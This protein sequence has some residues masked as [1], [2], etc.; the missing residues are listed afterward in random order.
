MTKKNNH[1]EV[2]VRI[3]PSPTGLLHFGV[4]R[5]AL[6]N[7]LFAKKNGG[8]FIV[9]IEDTDKER[10]KKKYETSIVEGFKWL[11]LQ[12]DE[13]PIRQ[14]ERTELYKKYLQKLL[15]SK[16]AFWCYHTKEEL[17]KEKAEQMKNGEAPRHVC[18]YYDLSEKAGKKFDAK[19]GIIRFRSSDQKIVFK[20]LIRGNLEFDGK[21]LGDFSIAKNEDTP[22]YNLAVVVDDDEMR[23]SHVMRGEDH[24]SN[25][26]KQIVIYEA[27]GFEQPQFAHFPMVLNTDR[28]KMSKR[29]N[30]VSLIAY[31]EEGYLPEAMV[32]FM[33]LLGWNPGTEQEIFSL[34]ELTKVFSLERVHKGG[35]VFDIKRLEWINGH[36]IRQMKPDKL[37]QEC[38]PYLEEAGLIKK[39]NSKIQIVATKK[40]VNLDYVQR[41]VVLEQERL[42]KL[43]EIGELTKFFFVDKLDYSAELLIWKKM[44]LKDVKKN[45]EILKDILFKT[46]EFDQKSLERTIMPLTKKHGTGE[47]L[48]PLRVSLTGQKASPGPFEIMGVLG[49]KETLA[50]VGKAIELLEN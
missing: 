13:G 23:I 31:K 24:I 45:L 35:A 37:T 10:S 17:E 38:V 16:K 46:K 1:Q 19:Q 2:R 12:W 11:G 30:I 15:K 7:Y 34:E 26:P 4:A 49:Q 5:A 28:S 6:F 20:D 36:Y 44:E 18:D 22:L 9:R 43:S 47:L 8:K 29:H 33:V 27:L 32:N 39:D 25:T 3:A 40:N 14:S 42:K 21:L 41:V 48:W 50:R